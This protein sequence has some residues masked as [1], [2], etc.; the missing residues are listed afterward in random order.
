[1]IESYYF[2]SI[3]GRKL[4]LYIMLFSILVILLGTFFHVVLDFKKDRE[5]LNHMVD[6][7]KTSQLPSVIK[8]L[9]VADQELIQIKLEEMLSLPYIAYLEISHNGKTVARAGSSFSENVITRSYP[10]FYSFRGR[11]IKLGE[12][13]LEAS[14]I[15]I[16]RRLTRN[17]LSNLLILGSFVFLVAFFSFLVFYFLIGRDLKILA[18]YTGRLN[19]DNLDVP[20]ELKR[21]VNRRPDEIGMVASS[22]N[23]MR[24]NLRDEIV[25]LKKAEHEIARGQAQFEAMF[26]SITD[27]LVFVDTRRR[28][29]RINPA[30]TA[31]LGYKL[32]EIAG[33][34]T[35]VIYADP[36]DYSDQGQVR[37]TVEGDIVDSVYE[38][39]YRRKDGSVF[40][41]ETL[42]V[43]VSDHT[44]E[45]IG[46]LGIIRDITEK[47]LALEEKK[48]LE[49][50]LRQS[51]K[52]EA[53]G[54]MAGGIAHDFNNILAIII[55]NNDFALEDLEPDHPSLHSLEQV[56]EAA[57]RAKELVRQILSFSRQE[58][59]EAIPLQPQVLVK[60]TL[61]LLRSTTPTTVSI[62]EK[63]DPSCRMIKTNPTQFH[64][65]IMNLFSNSVSAMDE[66]G[67]I[68]LGLRE[69]ELGGEDWGPDEIARPGSYVM[70]SV[71]DTGTGMD[72]KTLERIFDPFY[73]TKQP[74]K[75]TG[76]GLAVVH[77][78]VESYYGII[79][80]DSQPGRGSSFQI[81]FPV[82]EG[83]ESTKYAEPE[84]AARTGTERILLVDDEEGL[85]AMGQR[86]LDRLG[87]K[88]TTESNSCSAL[89]IFQSE[90]D[91]FDVLITDQAMPELS[92]LEL[93]AEIRKIRKDL[94]IILCTGYS[95]KVS[96]ENA[97]EL[98]IDVL[99]MKPYET[100]LLA[101]AIRKAIERH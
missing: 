13:Y 90:P 35:E 91:D 26:N 82:V 74:G 68:E 100:K 45:I 87:Y 49:A 57:D 21:D 5:H 53:L 99:V 10:L 48:R 69:V 38:V 65:L 88:V 7:I 70:L 81:Y 73:T 9:W 27:S 47:K 29:V 34:T 24:E 46:F 93:I 76:M 61:K 63:I 33:K 32:D 43:K 23:G 77:G 19:L 25:K 84:E 1:M 89:K 98:G 97:E 17:I 78:I 42:G 56:H 59:R 12:L 64:Q 67:W 8:S 41:G 60:E 86:I 96:A 37:Y 15:E 55:G 51:Y 3:L 6:Q 94:P 92:G 31:A 52:M 4:I 18:D 14:Q 83:R 40:T 2:K 80:V 22:L 79:R 20:L 58:K 30:F 95:T 16:Y 66:K 50:S 72:S 11:D 75:G 85:A 44:G 28:I 62:V 39:R 36:A 71:S 101:E 54:T